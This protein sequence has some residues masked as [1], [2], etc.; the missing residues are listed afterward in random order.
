MLSVGQKHKL[1]YQGTPIGD[2][3]IVGI[4]PKEFYFTVSLDDG[5]NREITGL[6]RIHTCP[7]PEGAIDVHS[8]YVGEDEKEQIKFKVTHRT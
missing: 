5:F 1:T 2:I 6:D 8:P 7:I 4:T 3:E